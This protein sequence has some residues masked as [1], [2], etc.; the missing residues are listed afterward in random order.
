MIAP[1]KHTGVTLFKVGLVA[2]PRARFRLEALP[3]LFVF[4][5]A[6]KFK[7]GQCGGNLCCQIKNACDVCNG[8][9]DKP[10]QLTLRWVGTGGAASSIIFSADDIC[11]KRTTL[12]SDSNSNEVVLDTASC[13]GSGNKLPTNINFKVNG[14]TTSFHASCSQPLNLGA[15]SPLRNILSLFFCSTTIVLC[16]VFVFRFVFCV[17]FFVCILCFT[18]CALFLFVLLLLLM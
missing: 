7:A 1:P 4:L 14:A 13:F 10:Q 15:Y 8:Q 11:V 12:T 5:A 9:K 2:W 3:N 17:C 18:F 6:D 16:F